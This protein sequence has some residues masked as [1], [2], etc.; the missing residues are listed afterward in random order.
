MT[1]VQDDLQYLRAAA[2]KGFSEEGC[3]T[4]VDLETLDMVITRTE[5]GMQAVA[6][7][8]LHSTDDHITTLPA[9]ARRSKDLN[10]KPDLCKPTKHRY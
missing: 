6:E 1:K 10:T 7:K 9:V 4:S 3:P 5:Q 8:V 2:T